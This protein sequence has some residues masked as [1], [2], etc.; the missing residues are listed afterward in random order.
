[1]KLDSVAAAA[2]QNLTVVGNLPYGISS[3]ILIKLIQSRSTVERAVLMFQKELA[4][5]IGAEPGGRQYGRITAML[6][7]CADMRFLADIKASVFYPAPKVDSAVIEIKFKPTTIY[8]PHDE[9]MLFRVI[10][11]AFGNRRK[12]LKNA[13]TAADLQIESPIAL[14]ALSAAGIDSTR[15]A[16]TLTPSEFVALSVSLQKVIANGG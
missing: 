9:T 4:Q 15:R 11:A 14:Q 12:T 2:S 8:G 7:Y 16:E 10:K 1:M 3:Q 6:R 13:L 5:R